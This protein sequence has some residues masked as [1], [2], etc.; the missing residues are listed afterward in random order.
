MSESAQKT[1][2]LWRPCHQL[3]LHNLRVPWP[4]RWPCQTK[5]V[6]GALTKSEECY[7]NS[8][9]QKKKNP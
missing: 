6:V 2:G 7:R 1:A 5:T 4:W 3:V 8:F 9:D